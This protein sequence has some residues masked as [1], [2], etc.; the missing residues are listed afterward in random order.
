MAISEG[1][2]VRIDYTGRLE[3]GEVF[4]TSE[5]R[6]PLEFQVGANQVVPGFEAGVVGMKLGEKKTLTIPPEEAYGERDERMVRQVPRGDIN[7]EELRPGHVLALQSPDGNQFHGMVTEV[8]EEDVTLDFNHF[9]AG[10][11]LVF[12][13]KI[14]GVGSE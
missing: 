2:T 1:D 14:V 10:K 12:E 3:S 6:G 7:V 11:T 8:G 13:V 9:L 5:G 4:D